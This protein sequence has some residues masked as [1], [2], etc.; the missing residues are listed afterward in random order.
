MAHITESPKRAGLMLTPGVPIRLKLRKR[1]K[2][3]VN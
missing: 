2:T 3:R 1:E